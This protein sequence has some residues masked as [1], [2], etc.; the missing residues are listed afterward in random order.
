M[1]NDTRVVK[2]IHLWL[3]KVHA[4]DSDLNVAVYKIEK[5]PFKLGKLLFSKSVPAASL[6]WSSHKIEIALDAKFSKKGRYAIVLSTNAKGGYFGFEGTENFAKPQTALYYRKKD[7]SSFRP[8]ADTGAG[9][10]YSLQ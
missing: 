7:G 3:Y 5:G 8:V 4:P 1:A 10:K 9:I 6:G 2:M